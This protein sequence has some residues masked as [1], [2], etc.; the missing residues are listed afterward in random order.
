MKIIRKILKSLGVSFLLFLLCLT[1]SPSPVFA[2]DSILDSYDNA[3]NINSGSYYQVSGGQLK[4]ATSTKTGYWPMDEASGTSVADSSGNSYTGTAA[5]SPSP[6]GFWKM[7]EASGTSVADS[8][9][10]STGTVYG[11]GGAATGGTITQ[12]GGYTTHAFTTVGS[13]TFTVNSPITVQVLAIA[14]G[15]GGGSVGSPCTE[16]GGGGGAGGLVY[17]G[18]YAASGS[19]SV[20]VGG[21]GAI[22][23]NGNDSI[24]GAITA[25]GGGWGANYSCNAGRNGN[26]GGSGGG[27]IAHNNATG[28]GGAGSPAGQGY[29]GGNAVSGS[30]GS[31][32]PSKGGGG[33][34]GGAGGDAPNN[35]CGGG[36][37]GLN[38][39]ATYGTT[40]GVSGWFAGGGGGGG[41]GGGGSGGGGSGGAG[42]ANTGGG[43]GG[44]AAGGS[45]IVLVRY[46][47]PSTVV[48]GQYVN[49]RKFDGATD[50]TD[51][52]NNKLGPL[53][54][55][56]SS[57]TLE[58]WIK[59]AGLPASGNRARI[60][61]ANQNATSK[62]GFALNLYNNAGSV[63][64]EAGGRS[65]S[66]DAY[67]SSTVSYT[68][69]TN[70]HHV[71]GVF[72]FSAKTITLY[73]DGVAQTPTSVTWANT[74][75]TQGTPDAT[76]RDGIGGFNTGGTWGEYFNGK[77]DDV[78]MYRTALTSAQITNDK[79]DYLYS[80]T[81]TS[82]EYSNARSFNG[83]SDYINFGTNFNYTSQ[84]FTIS[85][86]VNPTDFSNSPVLFSNGAWEGSG[87]YGEFGPSGYIVFITNQA[88]VYQQ[89]VS[90]ASFTTG[91]W[92]HLAITRSGSSVKIYRNG[93]DITSSAGTHINPTSTA[94]PFILGTYSVGTSTYAY[95][96]LV[97]DLRIYNFARTQ[98]QIQADMNNYSYETTGTVISK[99]LL[100][101]KTS[102]DGIDEFIY[103]LSSLPAA[104]TATLW[105]GQDG[106][107]WHSIQN[108]V[109]VQDGA[110]FTLSQG[111]N[112]IAIHSLLWSGSN[113]YYK[114]V[115]TSNGSATPTL[116]D[117][118]LNYTT[119]GSTT[120]GG[121][122][123]PLCAPL[124]GKDWVINNNCYF[125]K[126]GNNLPNK[127]ID[128]VDNGNLTVSAYKA[129]TVKGDQ[130]LARNNGKS[131]TIQTGGSI[132]INDIPIG[133]VGGNVRDY[134]A[135][136]NEGQAVGTTVVAGKSATY[137]TARSFNGSSDY[138]EVPN[139]S[140]LQLTTAYTFSTWVYR[141][142]DNGTW[143][144]ILSKSGTAGG[145]DYW[146]QIQP[147][148]TLNCGVYK[149]DSAYNRSSSATVPTGQWTHVSCSFDST[150][151][152]NMYIN[153][154]L[155][156]GT[157]AGTIG[158]ARTST[159]NFEIG[160]LGSGSW[161][162]SFNGNIDDVRIYNYARSVDQITEDMNYAANP[163]GSIPIAWYRFEDGGQIKETNLWSQDADGDGWTQTLETQDKAQTDSPG[164]GWVRRN[165]II[166]SAFGTGIDGPATTAFTSANLNTYTSSGRT[167]ADA[168]NYN[169]ASFGSTTLSSNMGS[170][171]VTT[172]TIGSN[173]S[174]C[175]AAGDNVIVINE[176]GTASNNTNVGNW[177]ML[178]I[179]SVSAGASS[180]ITFTSAK[181]KC[182]GEGGTWPSCTDGNIGTAG[183]YQRVMIQRLPQYQN[184][185]I[186]GT[187]NAT[188][189][190]G[191]KGGVVAFQATGTV[192]NSGTINTTS[193]GY[194]GG[195]GG[196]GT[197]SNGESYDGY[198]GTGGTGSAA[199]TSGGGCSSNG[200]YTNCS[201][202]SATRSGGGGGGL[203]PNGTSGTS[204][205]AGGGGGNGN[206]GGGGGGGGQHGNSTS[207][208]LGG[209][210]GG[211]GT[212]GGGGGGGGSGTDKAGGAG[213]TNSA[214]S[215]GTSG[216]SGGAI[217]S[218]A[219]T[220]TG[221]NPGSGGGGGGG[222][223]YCG[224]S[225]ISSKN[226]KIFLGGGGGGGAH[227][228]RYD[229]CNGYWVDD[230]NGGAG[231]AGGGIIMIFANTYSVSGSGTII[232]N[233][234]A[235]GGLAGC[236][237]SGG[238]GNGGGGAGGSILVY[239]STVTLG[240]SSTASGLGGGANGTASGI[241]GTGG[242][243]RI[244]V[245][246][247]TLA[248]TNTTTP[249]YTTITAP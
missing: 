24:F 140:S 75:Y 137:G 144:R 50:Y 125:L 142:A 147:D 68:D 92:Q 134:S 171:T 110:G 145:Y 185:T 96:G 131:I 246:Y 157:V 65:V 248:G 240:S 118:T 209:A 178:K 107:H 37:V 13:S 163:T 242:V 141:S 16:N 182:Y 187:L 70:W 94:L 31:A 81:I 201:S 40:Y 59:A 34:A 47:T 173:V 51:L 58:A 74:T 72:D 14:G 103:N 41:C 167:C 119:T 129:L 71:A 235:G 122:T 126:T 200:S 220:G 29:K 11:T 55:G 222:G 199:G 113:F 155:S 97:D 139:N 236:I 150:N 152:F 115:F 202:S 2:A 127:N 177:E 216:G 48:T 63:V 116:D 89:T 64:L 5:S 86:W 158:V 175:L 162:Y 123:W 170:P 38:Y 135:N 90:T 237:S 80:P 99:N 36:G 188:A 62:T 73:V 223:G 8:A 35:G 143:E 57:L 87:Y 88:G 101:G 224:V 1:S 243:G 53:V 168:I 61:S 56:Y 78:R 69:T 30:G 6:V 159:S 191:Q 95:K 218:G 245:G 156:N 117:I 52:G 146:M 179:Y 108:G 215:A 121:S 166:G 27:A 39:S 10:S 189:W 190:N 84:S 231:G 174:G 194:G 193:L 192:T 247:A 49:A 154:S 164:T 12:S 54:N 100:T 205:G 226:G 102:V 228:S 214:G 82:G 114:V 227:A 130:I 183:T 26:A 169:A 83:N 3:D 181:K 165:T 76:T 104:T 25:T 244:A 128:G 232:S 79:N 198:V 60:I 229:N 23:T 32:F 44:N 180:T 148:D 184:V 98:P 111:T 238:G 133:G 186:S 105:V 138:I 221:G 20:T 33:G 22:H 239:G 67:Q 160:R 15:G 109:D 203:V 197:G 21:G 217:G 85:M 196:A 208:V 161:Y 19:I 151:G 77:I 136:N 46:P 195:A 210:G 230:S 213:G 212:N 9:G 42:T 28:T 4:M 211:S 7:D 204:G 18:T 153:G 106:S 207:N 124:P 241:G 43:G 17:N 234:T 45:G 233:G 172:A 206:G 120:Y 112:T 93:V 176:Q 219:V 225:D 149:T 132:A 66:T 249:T 91:S